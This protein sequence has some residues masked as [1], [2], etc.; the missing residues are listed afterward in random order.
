MF[1]LLVGIVALGLVH[2][3]IPNHWLPLVAVAK[4]EGWSKKEITKVAFLSALAHVS[5]TVLLG[6]VLGNVGQTL[7]RR[8]DDYV[9]IIAPVLLIV[10][11][12][13]YFTINLP[14]H[15]HSKQED[16]SA[17]KRSKRRWIL[18]F[19]VMMFLSPCLEVE[20]LFLSAGAYGMNH[21]FAMA[22][23]YA[24]VSIS[25]IVALVLL[26]FQGVKLMNAHF[27]EHHEKR[28]T[29]GILIGVGILSFF[30]H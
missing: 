1:S 15:H 16:V 8:Y 24:I 13:I 26:A 25:G 27:F 30:I 17:Y 7:A 2:A 12:L 10:F 29:G 19:V 9:H 22:V 11:G 23:A 6:I 20:S 18:I 3:L 21:V 28:L 4:A 14:H 5:G